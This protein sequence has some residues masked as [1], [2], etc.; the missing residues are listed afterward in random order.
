MKDNKSKVTA[1]V[2][3]GGAIALRSRLQT[4][5][6]GITKVSGKIMESAVVSKLGEAADVLLQMQG[7]M[8]DISK[9]SFF[10]VRWIAGQKARI[11]RKVKKMTNLK[12]L[13]EEQ[14]VKLTTTKNGLVDAIDDMNTLH[15]ESKKMDEQLGQAID[16]ITF[17]KEEL[18]QALTTAP[19]ED[20]I[21]IERAIS[22]YSKAL[23]DLKGWRATSF[24]N[25]TQIDMALQG[26]EALFDS[27]SNIAPQVRAL[28]NQ[29]ASL[30]LFNTETAYAIEVVNNTTE[31]L[32]KLIVMTSEQ[33]KQNALDTAK[34]VSKPVIMVNT[35]ETVATNIVDTIK[36]VREI[37]NAAKVEY[38]D[39]SNAAQSSRE[40]ITEALLDFE[41]NYETNNQ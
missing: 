26:R 35:I 15:S 25:A 34:I 22:R 32:N 20:K 41:D 2:K 28:L 13:V 29:T 40:R 18:E 17:E 3:S 33:S 30:M 4:P 39:V 24:G 23:A 8:D 27:I 31:A 11:N 9:D 1:L 7:Y 14:Q 16:E 21:E 10:L 36:G 6:E 37:L 5:I 38:E 19:T 12:T